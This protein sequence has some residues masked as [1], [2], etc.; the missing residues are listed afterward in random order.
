MKNLFCM[1]FCGVGVILLASSDGFVNMSA[2][3]IIG[4]TGESKTAATLVAVGIVISLLA[5]GSIISLTKSKPLKIAGVIITIVSA[6]FSAVLTVQATSIDYAANENNVS[7]ESNNRKDNG[8]QIESWEKEKKALL[9]MMKECERDRY[10]KPCSGNKERIATLSDK[11]ELAYEENKESRIAQ[12]VEI[13][14]AIEEVA[15]LPPSCSKGH[16]FIAGQLQF[17]F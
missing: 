1:V 10:Y 8:K 12:D 9:K 5:V 6:T 14:Y 17:L 2:S 7:R 11:I 15:G 3:Y 16:Q 4:S 13:D